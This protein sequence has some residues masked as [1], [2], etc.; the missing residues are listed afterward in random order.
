MKRILMITLIAL[1]C[2]TAYRYGRTGKDTE[3][4]RSA[5][6][7]CIERTKDKITDGVNNLITAITDQ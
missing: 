3:E 1:L 4:T 2:L 5:V 6:V 7:S